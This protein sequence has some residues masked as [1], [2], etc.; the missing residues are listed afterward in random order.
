M[1]QTHLV[2]APFSELW[3]GAKSVVVIDGVG[4]DGKVFIDDPSIDVKLVKTQK[5]CR[6]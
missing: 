1:T 5:F 2:T 6:A 4:L 3:H